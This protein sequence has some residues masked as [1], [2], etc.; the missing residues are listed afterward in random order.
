MSF[1]LR[2]SAIPIFI[3][4]G[5]AKSR[6]FHATS[7]M[8]PELYQTGLLVLFVTPSA[9]SYI[10]PSGPSMDTVVTIEL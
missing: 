10:G 4:H 7:H 8:S 3:F 2:H 6:D 9:N 1:R 5:I